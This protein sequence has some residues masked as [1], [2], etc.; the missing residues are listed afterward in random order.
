MHGAQQELRIVEGRIGQDVLLDDQRP[1]GVPRA[2]ARHARGDGGATAS[3]IASRKPLTAMLP[4][5]KNWVL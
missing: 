3:V 4:G 2:A 5:V 1:D